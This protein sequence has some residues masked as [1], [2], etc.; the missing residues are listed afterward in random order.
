MPPHISPALCGFCAGEV[1]AP[2]APDADA[3]GGA[4]AG[5]GS[6]VASGGVALVGAGCVGTGTGSGGGCATL[7][8]LSGTTGGG[9]GVEQLNAVAA[10][11]TAAPRTNTQKNF[12]P[13]CLATSREHVE[14]L[15][16]QHSSAR[17]L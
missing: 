3:A 17:A 16:G 9:G 5:E 11:H 7:G 15:E 4:G 14:R 13:S 10:L 2:A 6:G 8:A 1:G 12:M